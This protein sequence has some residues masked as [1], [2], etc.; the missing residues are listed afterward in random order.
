MSNIRR[1]RYR[2]VSSR[3]LCELGPKNDARYREVSV[4]K[5]P[6]HRGFVCFS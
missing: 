4:I 2:E 6:L 1:F 5:C 3:G